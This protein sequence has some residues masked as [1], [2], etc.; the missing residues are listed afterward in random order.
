MSTWKTDHAEYLKEYHEEY[1]KRPR[2]NIKSLSKQQKNY[3]LWVVMGLSNEEI[4]E[5]LNV[6]IVRIH[7]LN[8]IV[9]KH[10]VGNAVIKVRHEIEEML[11]LE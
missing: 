2:K 1:R 3:F 9:T 7:Q 4:A 11:G 6:S 10:L 8:K 5:K